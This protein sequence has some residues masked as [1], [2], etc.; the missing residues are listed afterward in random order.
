MP[1]E[2]SGESVVSIYYYL[3]KLLN[4]NNYDELEQKVN[5]VLEWNER[6]DRYVLK[7]IALGLNTEKK[8]SVNF[9]YEIANEIRMLSS[10]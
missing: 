7:G 5:D 4:Q 9:Y 2:F 8:M 6:H 3:R 10:D 1:S